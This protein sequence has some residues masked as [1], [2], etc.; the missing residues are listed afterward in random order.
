MVGDVGVGCLTVGQGRNVQRHSIGSFLDDLL[1][2]SVTESFLKLE[3]RLAGTH[4]SGNGLEGDAWHYGAHD[5]SECR[6]GNQL[7]EYL[8]EFAVVVRADFV[9]FLV[10]DYKFLS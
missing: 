3:F 6:V 10:H 2:Q 7:L 4:L 8:R 9:K 1:Q 5:L